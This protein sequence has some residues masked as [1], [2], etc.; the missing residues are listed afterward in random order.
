MSFSP[1]EKYGKVYEGDRTCIPISSSCD[2]ELPPAF[3]TVW[4]DFD[5]QTAIYKLHRNI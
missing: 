4:R 1:S 3:G 2:W 5:V